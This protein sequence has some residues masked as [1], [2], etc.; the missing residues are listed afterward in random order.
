MNKKFLELIVLIFIFAL[1]LTACGKEDNKDSASDSNN[2]TNTLQNDVTVTLADDTDDEDNAAETGSDTPESMSN[3]VISELPLVAQIG[4]SSIQDMALA[5]DDDTLILGLR[6]GNVTFYSLS[7]LEA[8]PQ[9]FAAHNAS[10]ISIALSPDGSRLATSSNDLTTKVWDLVSRNVV[11][12]WTSPDIYAA[13]VLEFSPDG[14]QIAAFYLGNGQ[15][16]IHDA[17]SGELIHSMSGSNSTNGFTLAYA[18]DGEKLYISYGNDELEVRDTATGELEQTLVFGTWPANG[19]SFNVDGSEMILTYSSSG[20]AQIRRIDISNYNEI[21]NY[22]GRTPTSEA[23]FTSDNAYMVLPIRNT[24]VNSLNPTVMIIDPKTFAEVAFL[25][26]APSNM[27]DVVLTSDGSTLVAHTGEQFV[28]AELASILNAF[29]E[30]PESARPEPDTIVRLTGSLAYVDFSSDNSQIL[31]AEQRGPVVSLWS[32]TTGEQLQSI[33]QVVRTNIRSAQFT[34]D[35]SAFI[36]FN[37]GSNFALWNLESGELIEKNSLVRYDAFHVFSD[38]D[39][40]LTADNSSS[41]TLEEWSFTAI[42]EQRAAREDNFRPTPIQKWEDYTSIRIFVVSGNEQFV[43]MVVPQIE[44]V[45]GEEQTVN[46]IVL[47]DLETDDELLSIPFP[48]YVLQTDL[49][50]NV[51]GSYLAATVGIAGRKSL[52]IYDLSSG[53]VIYETGYTNELISPNITDLGFNLD[54]TKLYYLGNDHILHI[55]DIASMTIDAQYQLAEDTFSIK[56]SADSNLMA[57]FAGFLRDG[58]GITYIYDS[59]E[60]FVSASDEEETDNL[61]EDDTSNGNGIE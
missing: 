14:T 1:L 24:G 40:I 17:T 55:L 15:S 37:Q 11:A 59:S 41:A 29:A 22:V 61:D 50:I 38:G 9:I 12:E 20:E 35:D 60:V 3:S 27:Q 8:E 54:G 32:I 56:F 57:T 33:N 19:I 23:E 31:L 48:D 46:Y 25:F 58:P 10:I 21:D 44:T 6:N 39:R 36:A 51:D 47:F 4:Y 43:A 49:A 45:E 34:P 53:E 26:T 52:R 18:P 2:R 28:V 16:E 30:E 42:S 13:G 7:N 5:P